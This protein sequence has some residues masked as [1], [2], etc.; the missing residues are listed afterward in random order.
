MTVSAWLKGR[1]PNRLVYCNCCEITVFSS[2]LTSKSYGSEEIQLDFKASKHPF[3]AGCTSSKYRAFRN[4]GLLHVERR[5]SA[6]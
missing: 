4:S 5:S 6:C 3:V 2:Y 1:E